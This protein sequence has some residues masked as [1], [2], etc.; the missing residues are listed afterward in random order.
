MI[1]LRANSKVKSVFSKM[2]DTVGERVS[3]TEVFV[4]SN[5][6]IILVGK[7][8]SFFFNMDKRRAFSNLADITMEEDRVER[9]PD[10]ELL[11][12]A[13]NIILY[14][15]GKWGG[16]KGLKVETDYR[17]LNALINQIF[18]EIQIEGRLNSEHFRFYQQG[19]Q[20]TYEEVIQMILDKIKKSQEKQDEKDSLNEQEEKA[21]DEK[22]YQMGLWYK[23]VWKAEAFTFVKK[24]TTEQERLKIRLGNNFYMTPYQCPC[25]E[26]NL[27]MVVYPP[28][29]EFRIETEVEALYMA[30]AYT[31]PSCYRFYTPMPHKLLTDQE[32]FYVV[33]EDDQ[34]AYEDY[35]SLLGGKG[36]K[37]S[38]YHFNV[39]ESEYRN[40][41][42]EEPI[43]LQE[44]YNDLSSLSEEEMEL[45]QEKM[46]AGFYPQRSIDLVS[47]R[48]RN[49]RKRR[50]KEIAHLQDRNARKS[51][52]REDSAEREPN[53]NGIS[54]RTSPK[55][56]ADTKQNR[57][58]QKGIKE[59]FTAIRNGSQSVLE[60]AAEKG[61]MEQLKE[62]KKQLEA[63]QNMDGTG[64]KTYIRQTD[65]AIEGQKE[66]IQLEKEAIGK[67]K[68]YEQ[69]LK[70]IKKVEQEKNPDDNQKTIITKLKIQLRKKGQSELL[71]AI[72]AS[73]PDG[74]SKSKYKQYKDKI[75]TY[76]EIDNRP[77]LQI[78]EDKRDMAEKQE[79]AA[80]V[81]RS[82]ANSKKSLLNLYHSLHD[83]DFTER[84]VK[85]YREKVYQKIYDSDEAE[86]NK[87]CPEPAMLSFEEGLQVY[88]QIA[89]GDFLP[90]L[91]TNTLHLLEERLKKIKM[92]ECEQL[93]KKL[94]KQLNGL[95]EEDSRIHL[96][97][98]RK[99]KQQKSEDAESI[100][101][102][103]ACNS[104]AMNRGEYEYPIIVFDDSLFANGE[105]GFLLTPDYLYCS[106]LLSSGKV[107]VTEIEQVFANT[108]LLKKGIFIKQKNSKK[109]KVTRASK[110]EKNKQSVLSKQLN[111]FISYLKEK[112][113]SRNISYLAEEKHTVKCCY[114]CAYVFKQGNICPKCGSKFSE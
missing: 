53:E 108:G 84:N 74:I 28:G 91:K 109:G 37:T 7:S 39:Y 70:E 11:E 8:R 113:E 45:L 31:C 88:D 1:L 111:D 47:E 72:A 29:K 17:Q 10:N 75:K 13:F 19:I 16:I 12:N 78:L 92:D 112:P 80:M 66:S 96:V 32:V 62:L 95:L 20:V 103:N 55:E 79:I 61:S 77:F 21:K 48:M 82:P 52:E 99:W 6:D 65:H 54:N 2:I 87:I 34:T 41:K 26:E 67:S 114:R 89:S 50:G 107:K 69:V 76:Q 36:A 93:V 5:N 81:K 101:I 73:I 102:Q 68:T 59:N 94:E 110:L 51:D 23:L 56:A 14:A 86:I 105:E 106:S 100:I 40:G 27:H 49:E 83:K 25:C 22:F 33:F 46:D 15:F 44:L 98:V 57:A 24:E 3:W 85:P 42:S 4:I 97:D 63:E 35:L 58:N 90:E 71:E 38:N 43:Q 30:R 9:M 64:K 60:Q 104:Y 18:Q